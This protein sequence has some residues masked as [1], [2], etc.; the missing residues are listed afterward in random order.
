MKYINNIA[1]GIFQYTELKSNECDYKR[2]NY[3][4]VHKEFVSGL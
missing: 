3:L 2:R 4:I 1:L